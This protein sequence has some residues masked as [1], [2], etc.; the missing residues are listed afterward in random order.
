LPVAT[1]QNPASTA[2]DAT[3]AKEKQKENLSGIKKF[4]RPF[5]LLFSFAPVASFAVDIG[6]YFYCFLALSS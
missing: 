2:K 6:F 4:L 5:F 1:E 3:G